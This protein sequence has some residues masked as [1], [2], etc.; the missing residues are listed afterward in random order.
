[1]ILGGV[2]DPPLAKRLRALVLARRRSY[3]ARVIGGALAL[4]AIVA[5]AVLIPFRPVRLVD[6]SELNAQDADDPATPFERP[7]RV[8]V[9][10]ALGLRSTW[11]DGDSVHYTSSDSGVLLRGRTAAVI[12]GGVAEFD[13]LYI[14][15]IPHGELR[16]R[17]DYMR[18]E[19][20]KDQRFVAA[21]LE[22][23]QLVVNT[24]PEALRI[25]DGIVNGRRLRAGL[26]TVRV[27]PDA[28][29][30]GSVAFRYT[31]P[32]RG[33]LYV[34]VRGTSWGQRGGDTLTLRSLL[35]G[36]KDARMQ[37]TLRLRAPTTA[38]DYLIA[39]TQSGEPTGS[40]LLSGTNWSC[41]TPRWGD[42]N[43]L[44]ALPMD[45]L[46]RAAVEKGMV[47]V[48]WLYCGP[49]EVRASRSIPI[50]VLKVEVR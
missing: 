48:P 17:A 50:A 18:A 6:V 39:W 38:G 46:I 31:T 33:I 45:Q 11:R 37:S 9:R 30:S 25:V 22:S 49:E 3:L 44:M 1:V 8:E 36:V 29:I 19:R 32:N 2:D 27:A 26:N 5:A 14:A 28:E 41:G 40:W 23:V 15:V 43:D 16:L 35:A 12:R 4:V 10:N 34:L 7:L 13:S 42:G 47:S 20:A 21:G 24:W